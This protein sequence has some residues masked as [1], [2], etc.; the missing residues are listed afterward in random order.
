[1][2]FIGKFSKEHNSVKNVD[3]VTFFFSAHR[4]MVVYIYA[5]FHEHILNGIK[6][7]ERTRFS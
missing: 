6:V 7:T 3:V 5:K 2:I 4:L 1:M